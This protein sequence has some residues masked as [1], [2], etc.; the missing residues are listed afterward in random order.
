MTADKS[1]L[2]AI[3]NR[4]RIDRPTAGTTGAPAGPSMRPMSIPA[5]Q[6]IAQTGLGEGLITD[7]VLKTIYG[8]GQMSAQEI[9]Q[10]VKLP[11]SAVIEPTL[12]F[13][14]REEM[15]GVIGTRG[16][17]ERGYQY[18]IA[19]KGIERVREALGRNQYVGPAPVPL[20]RWIDQVKSQSIAGLVVRADDVRAAVSHLVLQ[21]STFR[22]IGPAVNSG[23]AIFLYGP[24]GNGKTTIAQ[25]IGRMLKGLI[26]VPHAVEVDGQ[27]IRMYDKLNHVAVDA[28]SVEQGYGGTERQG[29]ERWVLC[30]RPVLITGGELTLSNLDLI[31]DPISKS[32]EAPFQMRAINGMFM[33]D[34]FGRQQ[35]RPQDLLNRWVVPLEARVDFLTLHT[36]KKVEIPFDELIVFS[37]NIEP[38]QLVDD[39]FL[40]RIRHK[41][42]IPDPTDAEFY[43]IFQRATA[44]RQIL[45]DQQTFIYLLQEWYIKQHRPLRSVH[46]R[47][48]IEQIIDI[49][50]Y[51]GMTPAMTK[52]LIDQACESYFVQM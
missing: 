38:R 52:E 20:S 9:V 42:H 46:P 36:G 29:D 23:R 13:L 15:V 14:K 22:K 17:G 16:V 19:T 45:F 44:A 21:P 30:K 4:S 40:R 12:D 18:A 41:I 6:S 49:T 47:D 1:R 48:L 50:A 31:Y 26:Y 37:T 8:S 24:P 3:L 32:Y 5:P 27:I 51:E 2:N 39:A 35:V 11:F 28:D 34:D 10:Q 7:L 25:A 33:I 43:Q